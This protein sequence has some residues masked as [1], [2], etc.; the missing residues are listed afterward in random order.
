MKYIKPEIKF[1]S[2]D[3]ESSLL[4]SSTLDGGSK[5]NFDGNSGTILSKPY[6]PENKSV[7]DEDDKE[8]NK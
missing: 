8:D 7:W 5:G 4:E 6:M 3:L 1:G 2:V